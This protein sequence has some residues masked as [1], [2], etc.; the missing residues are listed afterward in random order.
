MKKHLPIVLIIFLAL[1][2]RVTLLFFR[3]TLWFDELFSIHFSSLPWVEAWRFWTLETNPPLYTFLLR[4]YLLLGDPHNPFFTRF[5]A[6]VFSILSIFAL[7]KLAKKVFDKNTAIFASLFFSLSGIH[8]LASTETRTYTLLG[9]ITILSYFYF[10]KLF[11]AEEKSRKNWIIYTVLTTLLLYT[12]LTAILVP[13]THLLALILQQP[14]KLDNRRWWSSQIVAGIFWLPWIIPAFLSKFNSTTTTGWFFD[15]DLFQNA[16]IFSLLATGFFV[17]NIGAQF[18]YTFVIIALVVA[19]I[20]ISQKYSKPSTDTKTKNSLIFLALWGLL[21]IVFT[22]LFSIFVPKYVL[23]A[24]PALYILAGYAIT[25]IT[26]KKKSLL[27]ITIAV[28]ISILPSSTLIATRPVFSWTPFVN[29]VEKEANDNSLVILAFPETLSWQHFYKGKTPHVGLY[30]KE[31]NLS[32]EERIVRYNW[33]KQLTSD[34]ELTLWLDKTIIEH[35]AE[36]IFI[37]QNSISFFWLQEILLNKG[38]VIKEKI[39]APGYSES[40]LFLLDAPTKDKDN[41]TE[42]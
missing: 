11:F 14:N 35:N 9:L 2:L 31:D 34:E 40:L 16:N 23:Y 26:Q 27:I 37:I 33:N 42:N 19:A 30:L 32:Y 13:L 18:I 36:R 29:F 24:Y 10:Y 41:F 15:G 1:T 28:L 3:G 12:H 39:R 17:N 21:P 7:Y 20:I 4:F 6:F 8:I 25:R 38:W 22:S 5:P